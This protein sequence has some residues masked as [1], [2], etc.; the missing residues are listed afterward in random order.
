MRLYSCSCGHYCSDFIEV[1]NS[2]VE[3]QSPDH[4]K[5]VKFT[6]FTLHKLLTAWGTLEDLNYTEQIKP[7]TLYL[8]SCNCYQCRLIYYSNSTCQADHLE[9]LVA[10]HFSLS[11]RTDILACE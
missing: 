1:R 5:R 11:K 7:M 6:D 9:S 10:V 3:R 4:F 8:G 2:M